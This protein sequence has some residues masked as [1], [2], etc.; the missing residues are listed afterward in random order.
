MSP[1][2]TFTICSCRGAQDYFVRSGTLEPTGD[3]ETWRL[4]DDL[5][6]L[7]GVYVEGRSL[8]PYTEGERESRGRS[9]PRYAL[10]GESGVSILPA[11]AAAAVLLRYVPQAPQA[12]KRR[13]AVSGVRPQAGTPTS[14]MTSRP[15]CASR[16]NRTPRPCRRGPTGCRGESSSSRRSVTA[17][18]RARCGR[19]RLCADESRTPHCR[20]SRCCLL[21]RRRVI[22]R[23]SP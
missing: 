14:S 20:A 4:P 10:V 15:R 23:I 6:K 7:R 5:Y 9:T 18:S 12:R 17:A 11:N 1:S 13:Y 2:P 16:P 19:L 21:S 8:E 22:R 3:G